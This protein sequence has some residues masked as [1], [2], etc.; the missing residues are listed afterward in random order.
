[1]IPNMNRLKTLGAAA[2]FAAVGFSSYARIAE[3][4]VII[5]QVYNAF[6]GF[7]FKDFDAENMT[8]Y[9]VS[10]EADPSEDPSYGNVPSW[11][12]AVRVFDENFALVRN[13][14]LELKSV[15]GA[16]GGYSYVFPLSI[17][18]YNNS[19]IND[20]HMFTR[21]L[22]NTDDKLEYLTVD[23]EQLFMPDGWHVECYRGMKVLSED[24]NVVHRLTFPE[25]Y[26]TNAGREPAIYMSGSY[27]YIVFKVDM[28][29]GGVADL[30]YRI[31][32]EVGSVNFAMAMPSQM[33]VRSGDGVVTVDL[34]ADAGYSAVELVDM[35]GRVMG[36]APV[37]GDR[38]SV[39]TSRLAKGTYV[40]RAAGASG[41]ECAK[42]VVR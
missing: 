40:L 12:Y 16:Y 30:F 14:T 36:G 23:E 18:F 26:F 22:F 27:Y 20:V 7:I 5:P 4:P 33:A 29:D 9:C 1:M 25:G 42:I 37:S 19:G 39:D 35:S 34:P 41:S 31:D 28:Q 13:F 32:R 24:G 6:K 21:T 15:A 3:N 8:T 17:G 38:V 11:E 2:L 10:S